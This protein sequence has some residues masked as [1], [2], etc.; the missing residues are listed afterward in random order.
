MK[1][2]KGKSGQVTIYLAFIVFAFIIIVLASILSPLGT[3]F[4][5]QMYAA[6][7]DILMRTN[8]SIANIQDQDVRDRVYAMLDSSFAAQENNIEVNNAAFQY[9]WILVIGLGALVVFLF[10]RNLIEVS[11]PGGFV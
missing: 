2:L 8:S 10:T 4:N 5:T 7:E 11:S 1:K 3:L 6:G 9:S